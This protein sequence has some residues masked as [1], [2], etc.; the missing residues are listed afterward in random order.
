MRHRP[1]S[2]VFGIVVGIVVA[3]LSY[4]WITDPDKRAEREQQERVV[5]RSRELL[6]EKLEIDGLEIVDP[7]APQ[8]RVGKVYVYPIDGGWEVSG[9]YRRDEDDRWHA[10]LMSMDLEDRLLHVKVQDRTGDLITRAANDPEFEV[11]R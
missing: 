3:I 11:S 9:F 10:Y 2:I 8:R 1:G 7:L 6:R 5:E 4:Q